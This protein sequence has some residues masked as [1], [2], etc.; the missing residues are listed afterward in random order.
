MPLARLGGVDEPTPQETPS[1]E[2]ER[3]ALLAQRISDI[4]LEIRGTPLPGEPS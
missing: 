2:N 1:W 3:H 4:G